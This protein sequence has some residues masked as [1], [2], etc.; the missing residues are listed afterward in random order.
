M[1]LAA[2]YHNK[3]ALHTDYKLVMSV[4]HHKLV[5]ILTRS[6]MVWLLE[7][8]VLAT[9]KVI[10]TSSALAIPIGRPGCEYHDLTFHSV[11]IS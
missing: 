8:I 1:V 7:L 11:T 3:I 6:K 4:H 10:R 2:W 5:L 9:F